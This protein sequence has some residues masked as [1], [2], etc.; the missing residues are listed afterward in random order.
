ML[1]D[2]GIVPADFGYFLMWTTLGSIIGGVIFAALIRFSV[3]MSSAR[4]NLS[5]PKARSVFFV[6]SNQT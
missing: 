2:A 5:F 6:A 3:L 4:Q 1:A